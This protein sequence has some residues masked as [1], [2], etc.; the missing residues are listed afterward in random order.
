MA[1]NFGYQVQLI[2][3]ACATFDKVGAN[4]ERFN[5]ELIHQTAL[6][7]LDT[8]FAQVMTLDTWLNLIS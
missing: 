7:S 4:G 5:A 6:A 2:M 3:D 8:E 1:G